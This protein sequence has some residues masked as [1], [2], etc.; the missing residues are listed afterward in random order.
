MSI[1]SDKAPE[2]R[3]A[4]SQL[5]EILLANVV[6]ASE[7]P[8]PTG[9]EEE[10]VRFLYDRFTEAGLHNISVDEAGNGAGVLPGTTDHNI[11]VAAHVDKIWSA[12][13]DHTISVTADHMR[14]RGVADNSLGVATLA[15]L[16]I[17]LDTLGVRLQSNLVLLGTTSSL[18]RGDLGGMRFFLGNTPLTFGYG[19]CLEGVDL[20]RLSYS[21]VGMIRGEIS[22]H[23]REK[24]SPPF[25]GS[26]AGAIGPLSKI[27]DAILRIDRPEKPRT[28]ILLGSISSGSGFNV[29]PLSGS[30]RFEVRS[31]NEEVVNRISDQ[32]NEIV[33]ETV[34]QEDCATELSVLARRRPGSIDFQHP[35]VKAARDT[36]AALDI[37]PRVAP[38]ISELS[39]LLDHGI[40]ALTLGIT[41]GENHSAPDEQIDI[42][43]IFTGV[44]QIV[45][46]LQYMD[47]ALAS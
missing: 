11:L 39:A 46:T 18:G 9:E 47:Q 24:A 12:S 21:S 7:I 5:K 3:D 35:L 26:G 23:L 4:L 15:S 14:G 16:P 2:Y 41:S 44:A 43:R 19:L 17:I 1:F 42:N 30:L 28:S 38:S 33:E 36:M 40:P 45:A 22:V 32:I 31:E 6:M 25:Q 20:G 34:A 37:C 8:S 29:P 10:L 13:D 27:V